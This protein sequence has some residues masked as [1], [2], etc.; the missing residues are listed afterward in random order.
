MQ[1]RLFIDS[2]QY[3]PP[4]ISKLRPDTFELS[5]AFLKDYSSFQQEAAVKLNNLKKYKLT[6]TLKPVEVFITAK[7]VETPQE[8]FVRESRKI[9]VNPDKE[10]KVTKASE[11]YVED[12]FNFISV[13]LGGIRVVRGVDPCS[14]YYPNDAEV[15]IRQ[16]TIIETKICN[17]KEIEIRR[18]ALILLDGYAISPEN[19]M[20]LFALSMKNIDRIDVLNSSPLLGMR[21]ANGVINIITK[22]R[23]NRDPEEQSPNSVNTILNG[24][25]VPRIFYS[26]KY[27]NKTEQTFIPDYRSTVFWEPVIKVE[28]NKFVT[29][30]YFNADKS[31]TIDVI[32]EGV[33][34][35]GIPITGKIKYDVK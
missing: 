20:S 6:D 5:L 11:N 34:E 15:Y 13:R 14:P 12:I 1:G 9:Y 4:D 3:V 19:L 22:I 35:E 24:F 26:P 31:T 8:I 16:Q 32:V 27:D 25:D 17:K 21:G 2:V 7:K 28:K 30:E 33:T 18:G 10:I 23:M 29:V